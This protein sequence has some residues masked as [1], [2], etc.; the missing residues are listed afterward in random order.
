LIRVL[1]LPLQIK[2]KTSPEV[3]ELLVELPAEALEQ[4][5]PVM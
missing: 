2:I 4:V 3:L 1:L 5:V